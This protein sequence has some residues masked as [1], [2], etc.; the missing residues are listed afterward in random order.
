VPLTLGITTEG[1]LVAWG[2]NECG[3]PTTYQLGNECAQEK[4]QKLD[5]SEF[6]S[7]GK[8]VAGIGAGFDFSFLV[9]DDGTLIIWGQVGSGISEFFGNTILTTPR[10]FPSM[11]FQVPEV[12]QE[13]WEKILRWVFLGNL[14]KFQLFLSFL[15][16]SFF[17]FY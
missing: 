5:I 4:P 17:I 16:K 12:H 10:V 14:T 9:V 13:K 15:K 2:G 7:G 8:K 1:S 6:I 11:K 3:A